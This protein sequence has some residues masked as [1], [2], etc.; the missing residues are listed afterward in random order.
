MSA[1]C[2]FFQDAVGPDGPPGYDHVVG[3]ARGLVELRHRAFVTARQTGEIISL[4]EWLTERD[5]A[6][7]TFSPPPPGQAAQGPV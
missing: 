2:A 3:L 5:E 6:P 7:G 4:W 1:R